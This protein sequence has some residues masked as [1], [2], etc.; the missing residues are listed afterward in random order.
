VKKICKTSLWPK[1]PQ[2]NT[3]SLLVIG[4]S[5]IKVFGEAPPK[6]KS[7]LK[8]FFL[9]VQ[10]SVSSASEHQAGHQFSC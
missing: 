8:I 2:N 9:Q 5:Q 6:S 7:V 4:A 1:N 10:V 3:G